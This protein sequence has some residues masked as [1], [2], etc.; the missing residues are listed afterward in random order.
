MRNKTPAERRTVY[1]FCFDDG[2]EQSFTVRLDPK[3]LEIADP[4]A[5]TLPDWTR[6]SFNRCENCPLDPAQ[7][8]RCP[9]AARVVHLVDAFRV[10]HS[11]AEVDVTVETELRTYSCRTS[12]QQGLS[13]L[14]GIYMVSSGCPIM[15]RFRPMVDSHLPFASPAETAYRTVSMYVMAQ[16]FRRSWGQEPDSGLEGLR[17][18]LQEI[19]KVDIGFCGRLNAIGIRDAAINALVLLS[20]SGERLNYTLLRKNLE[21]WEEI[22]REHYG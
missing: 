11:Y 19:T 13:A 20:V 6:L 12:L 14:L 18:I 17:D 1:R 21:P 7:N 16:F 4:P 15:N 10:A 9:I 5:E 2:R 22:F 8:E 3:T